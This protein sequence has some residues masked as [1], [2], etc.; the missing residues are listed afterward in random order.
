[1]EKN[2]IEKDNEEKDYKELYLELKKQ[3]HRVKVQFY[4]CVAIIGFMS[5]W[6]VKYIKTFMK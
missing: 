6:L 2:Y 4:V 1:M 5:Y 3:Y